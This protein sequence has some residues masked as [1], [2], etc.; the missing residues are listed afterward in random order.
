MRFVDLFCGIGGF[1]A[2]LHRLGH[3]CI[4][5][6]DIDE[7]AAKTYEANWGQPGEL[8]VHC[9]IREVLDDIPEM[10]IICAGFPCQP[11]SKSGAQ[12][13][14]EDQTRGTLFHD[15][16]YLAEKYKPSVL[17]L[18]N[19]PNL[20]NHDEGN[21]FEVIQSRIEELGYKF[22]WKILSPHKL[23]TPQIRTRVYIVAIRNDIAGEIEFEFPPEG[24]H[25]LDARTVLD[26]VVDPKYNLPERE[27]HWLRVWDDFLKN[28][29]KETKLPGH[30]IWAESF[31]GTDPIPD[32]YPKW[33]K[34]FIRKNRLLYSNNSEF[35][36]SWVEKWDLFGTNDDGER[37]IP[38]SRTKFEWQA[39]PDSKNIWDNL[40]QFRPSGI[41]VKRPNYYPALVAITQTP[42]VGWLRRNITPRECARL[43]D[44]DVDG[45]YGKPF[46]LCKDDK[47]AYKQLGNAVNVNV[48]LMI[49]QNI[50]NLL[51]S[52]NSD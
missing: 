51:E 43:Q 9:D 18:E 39:G 44:F 40:I 8:P 14:F 33:K 25:N 22:S 49:Q 23:G 46:E 13:G 48:I 38:P 36:D 4:F 12:A 26:F 10:D 16:C 27:V 47:Q 31:F 50:D 52:S 11:F 6:T 32:E 30:P 7:H 17:F 19:V 1:H 20:V 2:A 21:T 41:R 3:E 5:A 37:I 28:V 45:N 42:I 24:E 29:N 35:I 15:I 34:D